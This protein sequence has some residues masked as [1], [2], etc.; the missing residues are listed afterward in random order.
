M[1]VLPKHLID[2][3]DYNCGINATKNLNG[4]N[5]LTPRAS[6]VLTW[7]IQAIFALL[8]IIAT[9][10]LALLPTYFH[11]I[12]CRYAIA[13]ILISLLS[14]YMYFMIFQVKNI[15]FSLILLSSSIVISKT[16][17]IIFFAETMSPIKF[18]GIALVPLSIILVNLN[19]IHLEK[20]HLYGLGAG[21]LLGFMYVIDKAVVVQIDPMIYTFW[22][23]LLLGLA[24]LAIDPI[25]TP[26]SI[27]N[28]YKENKVIFK[29]L[30]L[31]TTVQFT[32]ILCI[33]IGWRDRES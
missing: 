11:L 27:K 23:V 21:I 10:K 17:G 22:I 31:D 6:L 26:R 30:V 13:T 5:A 12:D 24:N 3:Y 4:K 7:S 25:K 29:I 2:F 1:V 15:S 14:G 33:C 16:L 9:G 32:Y 28:A 18:I 20:N 8:F 19:N